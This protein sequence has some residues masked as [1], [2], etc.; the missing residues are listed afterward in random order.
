[1]PFDL[2]GEKNNSGASSSSAPLAFTLSLPKGETLNQGS[3]EVNGKSLSSL[4]VT[5]SSSSSS[6]ISFSLSPADI[7]SVG[8]QGGTVDVTFTAYL[9]PSFSSPA[10]AK[11][12][13]AY[14]AYSTANSGNSQEDLT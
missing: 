11:Y 1:M 13:F 9:N 14:K 3:V 5:P 10:S 8:S 6:G 2:S 7:S 4:G 12:E